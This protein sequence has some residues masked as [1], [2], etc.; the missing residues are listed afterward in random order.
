MMTEGY[1][2]DKVHC[3]DEQEMEEMIHR[4]I[5]NYDDAVKLGPTDDEI[6]AARHLRWGIMRQW[7]P[8]E[9]ADRMIREEV[10]RGLYNNRG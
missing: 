10:E 5:P 8:P 7:L 6:S 4:D 9:Q 2:G 3:R 1:R